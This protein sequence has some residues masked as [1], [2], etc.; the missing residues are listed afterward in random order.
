MYAPVQ[1]NT[2]LKK[3]VTLICERA[4]SFQLKLQYKVR[5]NPDHSGEEVVVPMP[6][7]GEMILL[8]S[9]FCYFDFS[10]HLGLPLQMVSELQ[11]FFNCSSIFTPSLLS[12]AFACLMCHV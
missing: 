1:V 10:V 11:L 5:N 3:Y 4:S 2:V 6:E 7:A 9:V 8:P 12:A